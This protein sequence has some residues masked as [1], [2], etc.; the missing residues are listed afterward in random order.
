VLSGLPRADRWGELRPAALDDVWS[1]ARATV[2]L[3][4]VDCGFGLHREPE[5]QFDPTLPVRDGATLATVAAADTVLCVGRVDP[6]GL[7]RLLRELPALREAAPTA[8]LVGV[9]VASG[10]SRGSDV[11]AR[12]MLDE[13][14]GLTDV[15]TIPEDRAAVEAAH[16][17][18]A[19]L[20][21]AAPGSPARKALAAL[22]AR[23]VGATPRRA[24]RVRLR[25]S[26]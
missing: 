1:V 20:A 4:V 13:R 3:T 8:Q 23:A 26:A 18:G 15:V 5:T 14:V 12:R 6:V 9:L 24:R 17:A 11:D 21:E 25:R 22:A 19:T 10:R 7:V 2:D 16:W